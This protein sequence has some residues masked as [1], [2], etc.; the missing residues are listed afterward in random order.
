MKIAFISLLLT[1][2]TTCNRPLLELEVIDT[3][4]L[5]N[6][7][8]ASGITKAGDKF[9]VIG[10]DSPYLF[11]VDEDGRILDKSLIYSTELLDG[12]RL[13][14]VKKPDFEALESVN[15]NEILA[16]GSGAKSPE[17]DIFLHITL[18]DSINVNTYQV[19]EFY[20]HLRKHHALDGAHLNI[21]G[22]ALY[23]ENIYLFNRGKNVIFIFDYSDLL[24]YLEGRKTFS[25]PQALV[26]KLPQ[27]DGFESGFSGATIL[28]EENLVL[29]TASVEKTGTAYNDGQIAGSFIGAIPIVNN[30]FSKK[31]GV[32]A[33]PNN[34]TPLK[35]ESV[36]VAE[37]TPDGKLRLSLVTDDD[38][39]N[40]IRLNCLLK[41]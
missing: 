1:I 32:A 10:D 29:F 35:V 24:D 6:V 21:E 36:T 33:I 22:V 30:T 11:K 13:D 7:P 26:Y 12:N 4:L 28:E 9:F 37:K 23:H 34:D 16:F 15:E 40:S 17:R 5:E 19:S 38:K 20:D 3:T 39:G 27:I 18:N 2:A 41:I 8:S 14:K 31:Y 25:E